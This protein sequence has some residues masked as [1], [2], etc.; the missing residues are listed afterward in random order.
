MTMSVLTIHMSSIECFGE[1]LQTE[2]TT[3]VGKIKD[4]LKIH[5]QRAPLTITTIL[6]KAGTF[7]IAFSTLKYGGLVLATLWM[8][9]AIIAVIYAMFTREAEGPAQTV[10]FTPQPNRSKTF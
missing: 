9:P 8:L 4:M 3:K 1:S 2:A 5:L 6:F 7:A 10:W